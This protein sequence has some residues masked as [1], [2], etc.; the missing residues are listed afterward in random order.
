MRDLR[1]PVISNVRAIQQRLNRPAELALDGLRKT[2]AGIAALDEYRALL[3]VLLADR[4]WLRQIAYIVNLALDWL[5]AMVGGVYARTARAAQSRLLV[6]QRGVV[7][8]THTALALAALVAVLG[9]VPVLLAWRRPSARST[10]SVLSSACFAHC[11]QAAL[12]CALGGALLSGSYLLMDACELGRDFG[13]RPAAYFAEPLLQNLTSAC[14]LR[15]ARPIIGMLAARFAGPQVALA[16]AVLQSTSSFGAEPARDAIEKGEGGVHDVGP[17]SYARHVRGVTWRD[18]GLQED[19]DDLVQRCCSQG[20]PSGAAQADCD[21]AWLRKSCAGARELL[22]A[23]DT[24]RHTLQGWHARAKGIDEALAELSLEA[25][26]YMDR[27]RRA[28]TVLEPLRAALDEALELGD[29]GFVRERYHSLS[30]AACAAAMPS[31]FWMAASLLASVA[32]SIVMSAALVGLVRISWDRTYWQQLAHDAD[33]QLE[34]GA[35]GSL[36]GSRHEPHADATRLAGGRGGTQAN[37]SI[38]LAT[39]TQA[40]RHPAQ[41]LARPASWACLPLCVGRA[42]RSD[43]RR[44]AD[45]SHDRSLR[46]SG[47]A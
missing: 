4:S 40:H 28:S 11:A 3:G 36:G 47:A 21:D 19:R 18:F 5:A 43:A 17:R 35:P 9:A 46:A 34:R 7:R 39:G 42:P 2:R 15:P 38:E 24:I 23:N 6:A 27:L 25:H 31:L 32:A 22:N 33:A 26:V 44:D 20:D 45:K 10:R 16:L 30:G 41:H 1:L 12:S 8:L 37:V 29:C 14:L 13:K